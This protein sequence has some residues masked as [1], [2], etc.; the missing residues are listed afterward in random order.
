MGIKIT[1]SRHTI[2]SD[3]RDNDILGAQQHAPLI[4]IELPQ[5]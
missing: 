4:G 2:N 5:E 3:P 1:I